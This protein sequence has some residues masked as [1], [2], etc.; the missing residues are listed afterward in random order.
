MIDKNRNFMI[1]IFEV[2]LSRFK[3]FN[4]SLKFIMVIFIASF[5]TNSFIQKVDSQMPLT[6]IIQNQLTQNFNKSIAQHINFDI[7][8]IF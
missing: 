4:N 6:Q 5:C 2:I 8:I 3:G 1:G 7:N